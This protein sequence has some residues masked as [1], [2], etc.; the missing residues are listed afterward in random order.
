[1]ILP[2]FIGVLS[3][4]ANQLVSS[5]S[6]SFVNS[7]QAVA[8]GIMDQV[9]E[10]AAIEFCQV[11]GMS[12]TFEELKIEWESGT[13]SVTQNEDGASWTVARDGGGIVIVYSE[14]SF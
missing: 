4:Y 3:L 1:M 6:S 13:T 5:E 2:L 11:H 12:V 10:E 7:Q 8:S 14:N 9:L